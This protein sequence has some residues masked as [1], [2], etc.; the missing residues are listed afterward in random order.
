MAVGFE[1]SDPP[2][3]TPTPS[4]GN[5]NAPTIRT[6]DVEDRKRK[7]NSYYLINSK[8]Y[9][10]CIS[11]IGAILAL[12]FEKLDKEAQFQVF[13]KKVSNYTYSNIKNGGDMIPLFKQMKDPLDSFKKK[14]NRPS[15]LKI[16]KMTIWRKIYIRRK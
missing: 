2:A 3:T 1:G 15:F 4:P 12:K 13:I 7:D 5:N 14:G 9:E 16:K 10:G 11:E 6:N 8:N